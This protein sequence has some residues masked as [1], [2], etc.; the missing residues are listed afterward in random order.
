[1]LEHEV[2]PMARTECEKQ[3]NEVR[4]HNDSYK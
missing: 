2:G 4:F 3:T 1:M